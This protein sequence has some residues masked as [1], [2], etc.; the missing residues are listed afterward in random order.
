[1]TSYVLARPE[2]RVIESKTEPS[3]KEQINGALTE[4]DI[5]NAFNLFDLDKNGYIGASELRHCL[6]FMGE[7]VT[8]EEVDM[9][10]SMLDKNVRNCCD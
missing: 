9:M 4:S 3:G 8:D 7:H 6:I 2:D 10:I 1:M 5:K